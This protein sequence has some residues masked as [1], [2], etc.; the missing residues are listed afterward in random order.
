MLEVALFGCGIKNQA[1]SVPDGHVSKAVVLYQFLECIVNAISEESSNRILARNS[2]VIRMTPEGVFTA[3]R[4]E[5]GQKSGT[6]SVTILSAM[7][8][9]LR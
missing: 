1:N 3:L 6:W 4:E 7:R 5:W 2:C 8:R 9:S